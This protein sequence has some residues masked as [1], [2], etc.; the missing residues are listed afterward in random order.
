MFGFGF[1]IGITTNNS[2]SLPANALLWEDGGDLVGWGDGTI[3]TM[4]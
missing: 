3:I 4:E 2:E 1:Q